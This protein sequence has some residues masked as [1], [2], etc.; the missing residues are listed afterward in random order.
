[1]TDPTARPADGRSVWIPGIVAAVVAAAVNVGLAVLMTSAGVE[2]V[3]PSVPDKPIPPMGFAVLTLGFSLVGVVLAALLARFA[4][5]P[6]R[7]F[8][9][10]TLVL[11]ALSLIPDFTDLLVTWPTATKFA[12]ALTHLVAAAIVIPTLAKRLAP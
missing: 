10:T 9:I 3:D 5:H 12:L 7:T 1:M 8:V 2:F 6:R 11:L 4:R